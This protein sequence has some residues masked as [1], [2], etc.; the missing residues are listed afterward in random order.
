MDPKTVEVL[1]NFAT[2]NQG[3][4][5]EPGNTIRT[6]T[7]AK[8]IFA[9]AI[10]PD[11]FTTGFAIYNLNEFLSVLSLFAVPDLAYGEDSVVIKQGK[12]RARYQYS[13][14]A[15]VVSPPPGKSIPVRNVQLEFDMTGEELRNLMKAAAVLKA[16]D[17]IFTRDGVRAFNKK[18]DA[19]DY[20]LSVDGIEGDT[21][22]SFCLKL[23]SMKMMPGDYHVRVT[24]T[25]VCFEQK[26]ADGE[27]TLS[28]TLALERE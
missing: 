18:L 23:D 12:M 27:P 6:M 8:N 1:K 16:T 26:D 2:I 13:S 17:L 4:L 28:Y 5:I 3:I 25:V 10:V 11:T 22:K 14:P 9:S 7:V 19:N 21:D 15:V 20:T 24:D